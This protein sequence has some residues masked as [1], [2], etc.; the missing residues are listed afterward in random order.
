MTVE[1]RAPAGGVAGEM[2]PLYQILTAESFPPPQA[3]QGLLHKLVT[4]GGTRL[5]LPRRLIPQACGTPQPDVGHEA[6]RLSEYGPVR[7]GTSDSG[8]RKS[9]MPT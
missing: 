2:P 9:Q 6:E 3:A 8:S 5:L 7:S 4:D 1:F